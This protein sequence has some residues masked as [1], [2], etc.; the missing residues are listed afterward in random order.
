MTIS[1]ED[2]ATL[3]ALDN[4]PYTVRNVVQDAAAA[5][6]TVIVNSG[7][8]ARITDPYARLDAAIYRYLVESRAS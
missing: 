7:M 3:A 1:T 8:C 6:H 2:R 5:A 4:E